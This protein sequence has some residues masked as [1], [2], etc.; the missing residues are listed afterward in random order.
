MRRSLTAAVALLTVAGLA[1]VPAQ[2]AK[3]KPK[4][5]KG[6][7][8]LTLPPDP[9]KEV[10]STAD[11]DGCSGLSPVSKDSHP[12][13][14]PAAGTLVVK[15]VGDNPTGQTPA[16]GLDWDLYLLADG[17]VEASADGSTGVEEAAIK[18]KKKTAITIDACNLNGLPGAKVTYTFTYR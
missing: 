8:T 7:Y 6:S 16:A 9:T 18:V 17:A 5:I 11:M 15:L 3:P 1:A 14:I 13:T 10:T 2:A 4:P 12:F